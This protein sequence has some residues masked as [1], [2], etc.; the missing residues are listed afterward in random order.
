MLRVLFFHIF[1]YEDLN[2]VN[3]KPCEFVCLLLQLL[4]KQKA[5][6]LQAEAEEVLE[7]LQSSRKPC[8]GLMKT[9][10]I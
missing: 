1:P 4:L 7:G 10:A 6:S 3:E 2:Y 9:D 5:D 8:S